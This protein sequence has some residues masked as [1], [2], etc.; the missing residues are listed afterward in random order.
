MK[1]LTLVKGVS[2]VK[3]AGWMLALALLWGVWHATPPV[4]RSTGPYPGYQAPELPASDVAEISQR[5][6]NL[7][8]ALA[9]L[10]LETERTQASGSG[11]LLKLLMRLEQ[12]EGQV[13]KENKRAI[14]AEGQYS[15]V[16]AQSLQA[17]RKEI[18]DLQ[19]ALKSGE[20]TQEKTMTTVVEKVVESAGPASDEEARAKL[21]ALEERVNGVEGGVKEALE[22]GKTAVKV[23]GAA[24]GGAA[25]WWQR[26][27]SS[28]SSS[29]N[30][31]L[32][33]KSA[34]GQDVTALI[35]HLVDSAVVRR[36]RDS[37]AKPDFALHSGGA[38]VIPALTS[39]TLEI[40]PEGFKALLGL[41]TGQGGVIGRPPI[42]A[43]HYENHNGHCWP[44]EGAQ[45]HLGVQLAYP[46][47]VE[48]V[49][50]DHVAREVAW[51]MR[52][53][54][55]EMELWG[56]VEGR[57][58]FERVR[59]WKVA[60]AVERLRK[61]EEAG[62][63]A[64]QVDGSSLLDAEDEDYPDFLPRNTMYVR[65][66]RFEYD[67]KR[68][69]EVQT[70]PVDEE[71]RAL[72]IDFGVVVLRVKSN[73]GRE[74]TCLYRVRVHGQRMQD[75]LEGSETVPDQAPLPEPTQAP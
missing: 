16:A 67:V 21:A 7:E 40:K 29:A 43:L 9:G 11:K 66:A 50:I 41:V 49:S 73:W 22:M 48:E 30:K 18:D 56:M 74:F 23:G 62:V 42:T 58:N 17:V 34:D 36:G 28:S 35:D 26:S 12:L 53:A 32:T 19:Q 69:E 52:S 13:K 70:F 37:I 1:P 8:N 64:N 25:T 71:V 63:S 72:G 65:I 39:D 38:T 20:Y 10:S 24:A 68:D 59:E 3:G 75:S 51:D 47:Y 14:E 44:F 2:L 6:L 60:K 55:R 46:A 33:I 61:A 45:G 15:S 57:E 54:P 31:G 27:S 5:L 4:S